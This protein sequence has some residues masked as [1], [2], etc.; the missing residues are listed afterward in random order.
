MR[1]ILLSALVLSAAGGAFAQPPAP[2]R[3]AIEL[4]NSCGTVQQVTPV[5]RK[6]RGG[7]AGV[8]GGA[9]VG[10]LL[11]NQIGGGTGKTLATVG[12]AVAGGYAGNEVQKH[13][14]SKTVWVTR[15]KMKDGSIRTFE[16]EARPTWTAGSV[17]KATGHTVHKY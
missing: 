7:A 5:K 9:V 10:G 8:V 11:G 14:T 6:G 3:A 1:R 16:Q 17:V 2:P 13:V 12:G 15:V 4:C